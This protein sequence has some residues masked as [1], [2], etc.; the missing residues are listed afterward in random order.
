[1]LIL[2]LLFRYARAAFD[3]A[4]ARQLLPWMPLPAPRVDADAMPALMLDI[5]MP[6][7]Y[8]RF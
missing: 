5:A 2:R 4:V 6:R 3:A 8:L 7:Y 1:M